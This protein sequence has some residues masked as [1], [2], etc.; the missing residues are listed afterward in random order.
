M[1]ELLK[2]YDAKGYT[3]TSKQLDLKLPL[4]DFRSV[5]RN[6]K[7]SGDKNIVID[8]SIEILPEVLKQAQQVGLMSDEHHLI[9]TCLDFHTLDLD[10]YRHGGTRITGLRLINP[11]DPKVKDISSFIAAKHENA[12]IELPDSE[13]IFK[14]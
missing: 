11:E 6:V 10:P 7:L 3:I 14:S 8:C 12:G 13:L 4:L 9:I 2:Y 5:L 1:A